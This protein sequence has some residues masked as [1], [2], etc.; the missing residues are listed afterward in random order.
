MQEQTQ[1]SEPRVTEDIGGDLSSV[2]K[3]DQDIHCR[4]RC[5]KE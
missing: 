5:I 1:T 4:H 2:S 3:I